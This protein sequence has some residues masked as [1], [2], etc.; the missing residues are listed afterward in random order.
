MTK[1]RPGVEAARTEQAPAMV[2][3][4]GRQHPAVS[5]GCARI[6]QRWQSGRFEASPVKSADDA[7]SSVEAGTFVRSDET[8][9]L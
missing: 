6:K 5:L 4:S 2:A 3:G 1:G 8:T 9:L 7:A